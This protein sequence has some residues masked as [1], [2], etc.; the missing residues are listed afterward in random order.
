MPYG[1]WRRAIE[2]R[3][4]TLSAVALIAW[5]VA[6]G[7]AS[8]IATGRI[9]AALQ[10]ERA[11]VA[12][13]IAAR[14][15]RAIDTEL[16]RLYLEPG[17][18]ALPLPAQL[19]RTV[20]ALGALL[21]EYA[22]EPYCVHLVDAQGQELAASQRAPSGVDA[23]TR[24]SS[25][26]RVGH[27]DWSI[28]VDQARSAA[29]EPVFWLRRLL[30]WA[31]ILSCAMTILLAWGFAQSIRRPI[32]RLTADAQRL[33][34]GEL[35][36]PIAP[37]G[38]DEIGQLAHALE[39]MR[40]AL[41]HDELLG[42]LLRKSITAQEEER[43]RLARELHD[44]TSQQLTALGM[45]I[46]L[47]ERALPGA[48]PNASARLADARALVGRMIDGLH[49]VIYDLRPSMLDD[50]GLLPAIRWFAERR[51]ASRGIAVQFEFPDTPIDLPPEVVTAVYRAVQEALSNI[52]RHAKAETV[53]VAC[54]LSVS[55]LTI[56]I[57]DDGVGFDPGEMDQPR[58]SGQG[59]GLL[60]MRERLFLVGGSCTIESQAGQGT[61]ILVQV[62]M[63]TA[64]SAQH[65][66]IRRDSASSAAS[67]VG[68]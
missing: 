48:P 45:Q 66:D 53:L 50:L 12:Q 59:L 68:R 25:T 63:T 17:A 67:A 34:R 14:V 41:V 62:P 40:L 13:R 58:E 4:E 7:G 38:V 9:T 61:R 6:V 8:A 26:A 15:E 19:G 3:L 47:V 64:E 16:S 39:K 42:R 2:R 56:E 49:R 37:A 43:K 23:R 54:D 44:E 60:G 21:G 5:V 24:V 30:V 18:G 11:E 57:E 65:A 52:E 29:L 51:L 32:Q 28:R 10:S 1:W 22:G 36:R 20:P 46:D 55:H 33:A 35:R 27:T 31:S